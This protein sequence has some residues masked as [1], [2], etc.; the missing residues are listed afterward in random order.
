MKKEGQKNLLIVVVILFLILFTF[1]SN[2]NLKNWFLYKFY[3]KNLDISPM[4]NR[5]WWAVNTA[6]EQEINFFSSRIPQ[7]LTSSNYLFSGVDKKE[8][9]DAI[10]QTDTLMAGSSQ[11]PEVLLQQIQD[12]K[13]KQ[14]L[15]SKDYA[16][17]KAVED[18]IIDFLSSQFDKTSQVL[19]TDESS[20]EKILSSMCEQ[21]TEKLKARKKVYI[22]VYRGENPYENKGSSYYTGQSFF[23]YT[24]GSRNNIYL[25]ILKEPIN[26]LTWSNSLINPMAL[27]PSG[28]YI[29][30]R[31]WSN[32][33]ENT[34]YIYCEWSK[35]FGIDKKVSSDGQVLSNWWSKSFFYN[36]TLD[37]SDKAIEWPE[38]QKSL[39]EYQKQK[40]EH[41]SFK[42][43]DAE[44][45]QTMEKVIESKID[46]KYRKY[47][48][49]GNVIDA[50]CSEKSNIDG[51][52]NFKFQI[53][54][55]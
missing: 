7:T 26:D 25:Y 17:S 38:Y 2:T 51:F 23:K 43:L 29:S 10:S 34:K 20:A 40:Q 36:I 27:I 46:Q 33:W 6:K 5:Y 3:W 4:S 54:K 12:K 30:C 1:S 32:V 49:V 47:F 21:D 31:Y 45:L 39:A 44:Q 53:N 37:I 28:D 11:K 48:F 16:I 18:H 50:K 52:S 14:D 42:Q 13:S 55:E 19:A 41:W 8:I 22:A 15:Y 24:K 9:D 35:D